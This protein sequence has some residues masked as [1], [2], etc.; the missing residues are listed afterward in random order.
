MIAE[1][2][3]LIAQ[4]KADGKNSTA[5]TCEKI[6]KV[7]KNELY[8]VLTGEKIEMPWEEWADID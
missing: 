4:H 7:C 3:P 2:I 8:Y 6:K 1:M 5:K